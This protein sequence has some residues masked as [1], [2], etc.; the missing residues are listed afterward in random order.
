MKHE[1]KIV[2]TYVGFIENQNNIHGFARIIFEEDGR[3]NEIIA[4]STGTT[5]G[6]RQDMEE[7]VED[8][9]TE[10]VK[11]MCY[12]LFAKNQTATLHSEKPGK[13]QVLESEE[14]VVQLTPLTRNEKEATVLA[15]MYVGKIFA[16]PVKPKEIP[17]QVAKFVRSEIGE[18]HFNTTQSIECC[19]TITEWLTAIQLATTFAAQVWDKWTEQ[20]MTA[21]PKQHKWV[22]N[23][24]IA[25]EIDTIETQFSLHEQ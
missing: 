9:S 10:E 21:N 25:C 23:C 17:I 7:T 18:E 19:N 11:N 5:K 24:A 8:L 2:G 4:I 6:S 14:S 15:N 13:V 3:D 16:K 1:I 22:R 20:A 12:F